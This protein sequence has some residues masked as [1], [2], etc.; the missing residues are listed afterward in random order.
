MTQP[1][2]QPGRSKQNY[3]TPENFIVAVKARLGIDRFV[4]DF[5]ADATNKKAATFFDEATDALSVLRF[6]PGHVPANKGLRRP[7]ALEVTS[8][9]GA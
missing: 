3:A 2:Q 9:H 1:A 8:E 5:A 6:T 4:H 7:L